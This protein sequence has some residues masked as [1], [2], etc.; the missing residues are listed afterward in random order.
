MD[1]LG[2]GPCRV[3]HIRYHVR[4]RSITA[5][6]PRQKPISHC[7]TTHKHF[8]TFSSGGQI[9]QFTSQIPPRQGRYWK[10]WLSALQWWILRLPLPHRAQLHGCLPLLTFHPP[11]RVVFTWR[12]SYW[13]QIFPAFL[14]HNIFSLHRFPL[15]ISWCVNK[16]RWIH[17]Q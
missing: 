10:I 4:I 8:H 2:V 1:R 7:V 5:L 13:R 17:F 3:W 16:H 12:R 6:L 15:R 11:F 14:S 9:G